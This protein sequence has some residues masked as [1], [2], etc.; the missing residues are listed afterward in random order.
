MLNSKRHT[1]LCGGK[2][3][4]TVDNGAEIG[5]YYKCRIRLNMSWLSLY[6][7]V[8]LIVSIYAYLGSESIGDTYR[9]H[10]FTYTALIVTI[11]L[12]WML[13]VATFW[14]AWVILAVLVKASGVTKK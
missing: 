1:V 8:G 7:L 3:T 13:V 9:K 4:K 11:L 2:V 12:P 5:L 14:P 6:M 10:G